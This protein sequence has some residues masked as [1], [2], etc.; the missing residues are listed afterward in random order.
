MLL[1]SARVLSDEFIAPFGL[2]PWPS[3]LLRKKFCERKLSFSSSLIGDY[4]LFDWAELTSITCRARS[5]SS[6]SITSGNLEVASVL[7]RCLGEPLVS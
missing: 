4:E 1:E 6:S 7:L 3:I 5:A 2:Y